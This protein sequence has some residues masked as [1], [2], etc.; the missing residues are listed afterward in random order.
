MHER[1]PTTRP[2][3][4]EEPEPDQPAAEVKG[5]ISFPCCPKE[6]VLVYAETHGRCSQ[7]CPCCGR[8]AIFDYDGMTA[9]PCR[10]RKG[11]AEKY[12][13]VHV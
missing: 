11:A 10:P 9:K 7:K 2:L 4:G 8:F 12:K 1:K 13:I 3:K 5:M 6:S